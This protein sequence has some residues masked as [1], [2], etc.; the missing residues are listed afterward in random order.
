MQEKH[1]CNNCETEYTVKWIPLTEDDETDEI[2]F[3]IFCPFCGH[4]IEEDIED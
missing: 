1:I 4:E 2:G 3:P